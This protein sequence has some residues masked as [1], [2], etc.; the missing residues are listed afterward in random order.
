MLMGKLLVCVCVMVVRCVVRNEKQRGKNQFADMV[1]RSHFDL[2][3]IRE[4]A[5]QWKAAANWRV[6]ISTRQ[7]ITSTC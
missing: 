5:E 6:F 7:S 2:G 4:S 1:Q 3:F